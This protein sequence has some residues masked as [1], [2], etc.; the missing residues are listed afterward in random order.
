MDHSF[1]ENRCHGCS[2]FDASG[3]Y[4]PNCTP[5]SIKDL[6]DELLRVKDH[7]ELLKSQHCGPQ[8]RQRTSHGYTFYTPDHS[9]GAS[10][11][12]Y[13]YDYYSSPW[14]DTFIPSP[15]RSPGVKGDGLASE[16]NFGASL[17]RS[18]VES[19]HESRSRVSDGY[20]SVTEHAESES[21]AEELSSKQHWAD[22]LSQV[23][24]SWYSELDKSKYYTEVK[25]LEHVLPGASDLLRYMRLFGP[26]SRPIITII[27]AYIGSKPRV[28]SHRFNLRDPMSLARHYD[29][30]QTSDARVQVY[31]AVE[32]TTVHHVA[33]LGQWLNLSPEIFIRALWRD[34]LQ[35]WSEELNYLTAPGSSPVASLPVR[36][37]F[38]ATSTD[39]LTEHFQTFPLG[40]VMLHKGSRGATIY[41]GM[42]RLTSFDSLALLDIDASIR[43]ISEGQ[44][45]ASVLNKAVESAIHA[46]GPGSW[47]SKP[48]VWK[49]HGA[50]IDGRRASIDISA[51]ICMSC[52]HLSSDG[53]ELYKSSSS[54]ELTAQNDNKIGKLSIAKHAIQDH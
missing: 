37:Q 4:E 36:Q 13:T 43:D 14:N 18:S 41:S 30:V 24:A 16:T 27:E 22:I 35:D 7:I 17:A 49:P 45:S 46:I 6:R 3:R 12:E 29:I 25:S 28:V 51:N 31:F 50:S 47:T 15:N 21:I 52:I 5:K 11:P 8:D 54:L 23:D 1:E 44:G 53:L 20:S 42:S 39:D 38:S 19:G 10:R 32:G 26:S 34:L 33:V 9:Y 40:S 2:H 48:L